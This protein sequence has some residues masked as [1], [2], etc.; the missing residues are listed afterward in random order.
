[1]NPVHRGHVSMLTHAK[2]ALETFHGF[3]VMGGFLSPS[4][5]LYV[6]PK[7]QR[8]RRGRRAKSLSRG[9]GF[10]NAQ[11]RV[12]MCRLAVEGVDWLQVGTWEPRQIG[13]WPD[14]PVVLDNLA[15]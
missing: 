11:E 7:S 1:M 10:A 5:D 2:D 6:G 4:H 12:A 9:E 15:K 13:T 3:V 8:C 14:F